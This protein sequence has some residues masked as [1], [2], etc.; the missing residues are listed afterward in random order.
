MNFYEG[1]IALTK[2]L[3]IYQA[4]F[5]INNLFNLFFL[6]K[7]P[8]YS[9][10]F[11][12]FCPKYK[13]QFVFHLFCQ[14]FSI[15]NFYI[16]LSWYFSWST[17][18]FCFF[19]SSHLCFAF[20]NHPISFIFAPTFRHSWLWTTNFFRHISLWIAFLNEFYFHFHCFN[21]L[22]VYWNHICYWFVIPNR[23]L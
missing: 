14:T 19:K 23:L 11:F 10:S 6:M 17:C 20:L 15:F 3:A 18:M 16:Q 21:W 12:Q 8:F 9:S 4:M 22:F 1:H 5:F 13:L 2:Y 7:I